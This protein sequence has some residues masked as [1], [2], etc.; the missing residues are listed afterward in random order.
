MALR[1]I[2]RRMNLARILRLVERGDSV[3]VT[4]RGRPIAQTRG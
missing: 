1:V 4:K 2:G 3:T